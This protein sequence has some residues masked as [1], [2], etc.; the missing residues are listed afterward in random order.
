MNR[1]N[2]EFFY[3][4]FE[5][6]EELAALKLSKKKLVALKMKEMSILNPYFQLFNGES[7]FSS[8]L[9]CKKIAK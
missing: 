8:F 7:N 1:E 2:K 5:N 3:H 9:N 4:N 6:I